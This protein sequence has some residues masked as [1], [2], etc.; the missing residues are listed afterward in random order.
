MYICIINHHKTQHFLMKKRF[1]AYLLCLATVLPTLS[2][3]IIAHPW[4]GK[5][6]AYFGDSITD[7]RTRGAKKKYWGFLQD[8][9]QITPLVYG[10]SGRQW[11]DIPRQANK[12]REE[13]GDDFDAI[14]I[15]MGT[16]DYNNAVPIGR[17]YE[18]KL[19]RVEY[20]HRYT[21]RMEDRMRRRPV[22]TNDTYC[23][24]IN[25]A[26]DSLKR[27]FPTK[28]IVLLT[29]IH[30]G[31]FYANDKN[32]QCTEDYTNRCGEYLD[33]YVEAVKEAGTV[34]AVPV[35]DLGALSGLYPMID[36]HKQYF[37]NKDTDALHPND[38]GHERM[39]RTLMYQLTALPCAF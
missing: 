37:T 12:L 16:N 15:F 27:M 19:E 13:H 31:G 23:G 20:G 39:A 1:I 21:K 17:W 30:R 32:W 5:R 6:V 2:Q 18:E 28:Q 4:S 10:V 34:W 3:A 26:M 9:L 11:D 38:A 29:P 33:A 14:L 22:M 7:P 36:T 24:R 35:I 25:I 8:W